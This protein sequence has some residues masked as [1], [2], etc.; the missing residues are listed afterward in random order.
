MGGGGR[1]FKNPEVPTYLDKAASVV[2]EADA[3]VRAVVCLSGKFGCR[4]RGGDGGGG[5]GWSGT[6]RDRGGAV[7]TCMGMA[8]ALRAGTCTLARGPCS[9]EASD[10]KPFEFSQPPLPVK[11]TPLTGGGSGLTPSVAILYFPRGF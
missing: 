5:R 9:L 6:R 8:L 4:L 7:A 1:H 10:G 2:R 11:V 3:G